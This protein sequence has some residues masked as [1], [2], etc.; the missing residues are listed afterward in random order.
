MRPLPSLDGRVLPRHLGECVHPPPVC[1]SS[2]TSCVPFS[3]LIPAPPPP[4][5]VTSGLWCCVWIAEEQQPTDQRIFIAHVQSSS[6]YS[7]GSAIRFLCIAEFGT[8]R[9]M[10]LSS[11]GLTVS[12]LCTIYRLR[13]TYSFLSFTAIV[14]IL[15]QAVPDIYIGA[16]LESWTSGENGCRTLQLCTK[17]R[18]QN[19]VLVLVL[20]LLPDCQNSALL[21]LSQCLIHFNCALQPNPAQ[22]LISTGLYHGS[23]SASPHTQIAFETLNLYLCN[24]A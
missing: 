17:K 18:H 24:T 14:D 19:C 20:V 9:T 8:V 3:S 1:V 21:L 13:S 2:S 16:K 22:L 23:R 12:S 6:E 7:S 11:S 5:L 10:G 15:G 4:A